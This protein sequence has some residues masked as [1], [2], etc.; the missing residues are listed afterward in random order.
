MEINT[1]LYVNLNPKPYTVMHEETTSAAAVV[2]RRTSARGRLAG[3]GTGELRACGGVDAV[4]AATGDGG[5]GGER[6]SRSW[7]LARWIR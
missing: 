5:R 4:D 7:F 1:S 2:A 3:L 6:A